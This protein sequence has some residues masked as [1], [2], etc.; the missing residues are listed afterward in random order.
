MDEEFRRW[1]A[2]EV[3][4]LDFLAN[5][6]DPAFQSFMSEIVNNRVELPPV[7]KFYSQSLLICER[8]GLSMTYALLKQF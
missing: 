2:R 7:G 8:L 1:V 6:N 5:K 4:E 3:S